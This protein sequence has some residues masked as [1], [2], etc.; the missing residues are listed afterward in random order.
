LRQVLCG[1]DLLYLL[2]DKGIDTGL[3][4]DDEGIKGI[5]LPLL[6]AFDEV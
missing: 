1:L 5:A 2:T 4:F 6:R 3:V